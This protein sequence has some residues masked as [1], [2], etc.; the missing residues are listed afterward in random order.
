MGP[1]ST[2]RCGRPSATCFEDSRNRERGTTIVELAVA[3]ILSS[4]VILGLVKLLLDYKEY[5]ERDLVMHEVYTYAQM[6]LRAAEKS[7]KNANQFIPG[8]ANSFRVQTELSDGGIS[9]IDFFYSSAQEGLKIN[10][11]FLSG[12]YPPKWLR[13][14]E[15]LRIT[16]FRAREFNERHPPPGM[17]GTN[18]LLEMKIQYTRETKRGRYSI[19]KQFQRL[20]FAPNI[21]LHRRGEHGG[22][23]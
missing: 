17:Q 23:V 4:V 1:S 19:E 13:R 11:R 18:I 12:H 20:F 6:C 9:T 3:I 14:G 5:M 15:T 8:G 2:N 16:R 10:N 7:I 21:T 22:G